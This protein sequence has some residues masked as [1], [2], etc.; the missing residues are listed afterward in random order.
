MPELTPIH[1]SCPQ[2]HRYAYVTSKG[3]GWCK[4]CLRH[5]PATTEAED[6]LEWMRVQGIV[7][8]AMDAGRALS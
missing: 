4:V 8:P 7:H 3:F 5:S 1:D 6:A 2:G